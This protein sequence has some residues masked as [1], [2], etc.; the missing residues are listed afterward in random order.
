MKVRSGM[1]LACCTACLLVVLN[2]LP[3]G[4]SAAQ[5]IRLAPPSEPIPRTLFGMHIHHLVGGTPLRTPWPSIPFG[6]WRLLDAYVAWPNLEPKKD[7]FDFRT[8]D[9]YVDLAG[10]H[11]VSVLMP[12]GLSPPWASSDP[13]GPYEG[14]PAPPKNLSDWQG[15][16]RAVATRYKGK[17]HEYE[18][19]NEPNLKLFYSGSVQDMV[20]LSRVAY[21]T[22]KQVDPAV[23]VCSPAAT[24]S[25][26][27]AWLDQYLKAGGGMYADAICY[28][29]YVYPNPPENM[30][31]LINQVKITMRRNGVQGKPIWDTENGW[32][33][34]NPFPPGLAEAYVARAYVLQWA[35][36][37]G[38]F[39]WYSWDNQ[40]YGLQ[41]TQ[42]DEKTLTAA[43]TAYAEV[44]N[45]L[46]GATMTSCGSD[47][48]GVWNC[49]LTRP[50]NYRAWIVWDPDRTVSFSI[51]T[52]WNVEEIRELGG[53]NRLLGKT[54]AVDIGAS[55]LLFVSPGGK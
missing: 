53:G 15:Y 18:M 9:K 29:F 20:Q 3:T 22:L 36:G 16:V 28:H 41:L 2:T 27:V 21:E 51:P 43:G 24:T 17:I 40:K 30:I 26:G 19:W 52:Q 4:L 49:A 47:E 1:R 31:D 32:A 10:E 38:R 46:V 12:L 11:D 48:A 54:K 37:V 33:S 39:Y 7:Q 6:S 25:K 8:L 13:N 14:H 45:W 42:A 44:E 35:D 5:G 50:G 34:P 55:P 23:T